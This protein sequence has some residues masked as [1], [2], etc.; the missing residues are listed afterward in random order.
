M[1]RRIEIELTSER[2]DGIW[3]WRAA[4]AKQP[5]GEL[6]GSLLP[7]DSKVG[8]VLR[9]D[10]EFLVD[11]IDI[12]GVL[13]PK[14]ARKE[15]D[16]LEI[17]GS[18]K[19]EPL[20][21]TQLAG[22]GKGGGKGKGKGRGRDGDRNKSRGP[23]SDGNRSGGGKSAP[24]QRPAPKRLRPGRTHRD[25]LIEELSPEQR[26]IAEQV[27]RGGVPAVREQIKK[28]N[29]LAKKENR[30]ELPESQ[31]VGIAEKLVP[32]LRRAEWRDRAEAAISD[33][34]ELD[35]RDLRSVV[36][37]AEDG[38]R[39]D[40]T[41]AMRD[42]ISE[43]LA[44]RVEV[45]QKQ[46]VD[47]MTE[48][49]DAGRYVRALR[50]SSRP[51]KAG[52]PVPMDLSD[53]LVKTVCEGLN[54]K[55]KQE[56]YA[57]TLD[58]LSF[59]PIRAQVRIHSKPAEPS[60]DLLEAVRR[61]ADKLPEIAADFG[62]DPKEAN[63]ARRRH[64][65]KRKAEAKAAKERPAERSKSRDGGNRDGRGK[66]DGNSDDKN[67]RNKGDR[68]KRDRND[69]GRGDGRKGGRD[70]G[71]SRRDNTDAARHGI[72]KSGPKSYKPPSAD[73][74][75]DPDAEP[76]ADPELES[77]VAEGA[78]AERTDESVESGEESA[79]PASAEASEGSDESAES[80]DP[81][82]EPVVAETESAKSE[83][84]SEPADSDSEPTADQ[85]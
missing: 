82:P 22:K 44:R 56:V 9:A 74:E 21:T 47:D 77:A 62:I 42:Q 85:D 34:E 17:V 63:A 8:E 72:P 37:A 39:D 3:T 25:A 76:V 15:P 24:A 36:V 59:S 11:G 35:L 41:R 30:P 84:E 14:A 70:G 26:P 68:D 19:S 29:D 13:A 31:V 49:L 61:T 54:G 75:P 48:N 10:A 53:R 67:D 32:Q 1:S 38:A 79:A 46:W 58:A 78:E 52:A 5:K 81:Q 80:E 43:G 64:R 4:G 23:R 20:V 73:P 12:V 50:I 66:G 7:G 57:Q 2:P 45:D 6:D 60:E 65:A 55:T 27:M 16:L 18:G 83:P 69:G 33:L 51:P 40:E 71:K 28:Q